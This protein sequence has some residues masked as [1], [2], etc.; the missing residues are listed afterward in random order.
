MIALVG[1]E[2][3]TVVGH[4]LL[5]R[6]VAPFRALGLAPVAV[7]P[8]R[9]REGIG[10]ALIHAALREAGKDGWQGVFVLGD[11]AFYCRFG[12]ASALASGFTSVYAGPYLMALA[13]DPPLPVTT[14]MIDYAPAFA[15]LDGDG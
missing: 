10:S 4:V 9:Q 13:L 15:A 3:G 6:M 7:A 8:S 14:G 2:L 11:P 5:S 12:F 1:V